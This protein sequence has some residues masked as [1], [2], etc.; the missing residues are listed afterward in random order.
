MEE[1]PGPGRGGKDPSP[2][3]TAVPKKAAAGSGGNA[4]DEA[5]TKP[6]V[7]SRVVGVRVGCL[8]DPSPPSKCRVQKTLAHKASCPPSTGDRA[9]MERTS[10]ATQSVV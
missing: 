10:E 2:P 7:S 8:S 5:H 1:I 9:D 4:I 6:K 3:L